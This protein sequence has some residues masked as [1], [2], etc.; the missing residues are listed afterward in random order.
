LSANATSLTPDDENS[1]NLTEAQILK[2]GD[3]QLVAAIHYLET[4]KT[5]STNASQGEVSRQTPS[6]VGQLALELSL[7][8]A[9]E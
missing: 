3:A 6:T 5:T 2:G 9:E 1:G 4:H 7:W 8:S